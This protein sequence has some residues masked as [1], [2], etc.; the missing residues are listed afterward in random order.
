M[1]LDHFSLVHFSAFF[2]RADDLF[3]I[4]AFREYCV[5]FLEKI[6]DP[7]LCLERKGTRLS[8]GDVAIVVEDS[9]LILRWLLLVLQDELLDVFTSFEEFF[10][11]FNLEDTLSPLLPRFSLDD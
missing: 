7:R 9:Y 6:V 10:L 5:V 4:V 3:D 2:Q 1:S 8:R 11:I